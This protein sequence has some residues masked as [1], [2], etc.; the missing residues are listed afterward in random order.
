VSQRLE[1][2]QSDPQPERT[3][4]RLLSRQVLLL[5]GVTR[6]LQQWCRELPYVHAE[7]GMPRKLRIEGGKPCLRPLLARH[8]PDL[9][10][11]QAL[12]RLQEQGAVLRQDDGSYFPVQHWQACTRDALQERV[13]LRACGYLQAALHNLRAPDSTKEYADRATS[14]VRLPVRL[15]AEFRRES[16]LQLRYAIET[17]DSWLLDRDAP[18]SDEPCALVSVHGYAHVQLEDP[19]PAR[20]QVLRRPVRR[21][22][23]RRS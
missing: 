13:S 23:A 10:W 21:V 11:E 5:S 18:D 15:L 7:T 19:D 8:F 22:S 16:D 17:L 4:R 14:T 3:T 2:L 20:P 6:L 9:P 12:V 1:K